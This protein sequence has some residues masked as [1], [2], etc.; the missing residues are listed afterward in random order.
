MTKELLMTKSENRRS[1]FRESIGHSSFVILSSSVLRH[2]SLFLWVLCA[3]AV[4]FPAGAAELSK[5]E[6][7]FFDTKIRPIF[8]ERCYQCHSH[9]SE[10]LRGGLML[11]SRDALLKGGNSGAVVV[12]GNPDKS[13]LIQAVRYTNEDL[14]MP[15]KGERL[16]PAKVADLETWV[17]M[18][19]PDPRNTLIAGSPKNWSDTGRDHWAFQP[20]KKPA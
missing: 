11:D 20:V 19:A 1:L 5:S 16:A 13:L 12:P 9:Q 6:V 17:K 18:G 14:Q 3:F 4:H 7:T 2:S 10:K 8:V 15:P